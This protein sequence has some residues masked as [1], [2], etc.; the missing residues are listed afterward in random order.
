LIGPGLRPVLVVCP[1]ASIHLHLP[2]QVIL[3]DSHGQLRLTNVHTVL[4]TA[5]GWGVIDFQPKDCDDAVHSSALPN[6]CNHLLIGEAE[7]L[8]TSTPSRGI[9]R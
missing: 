3:E 9:M 1:A 6:Q 5:P 8:R 2:R 4:G 7:S